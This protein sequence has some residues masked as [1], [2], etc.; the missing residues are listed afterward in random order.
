MMVFTSIKLSTLDLPRFELIDTCRARADERGKAFMAVPDTKCGFVAVH[1]GDEP[2]M[3]KGTG[4]AREER[5]RNNE[6]KSE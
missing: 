5:E 4:A 2:D 1:Q 3:L 6:N